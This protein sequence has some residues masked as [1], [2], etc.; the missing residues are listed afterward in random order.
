MRFLKII[1][2]PEQNTGV[3]ATPR[4]IYINKDAILYIAGKEVTLK[5][6][7]ADQINIFGR[8][9]KS[10]RITTEAKVEDL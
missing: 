3:G 8:S 2:H 10:L 5:D 9:A 6:D 1:V 7:Y 4:E